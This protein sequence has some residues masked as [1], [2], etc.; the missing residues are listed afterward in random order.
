MVKPLAGLDERKC[1]SWG[2]STHT[3]YDWDDEA[4]AHAP[5]KDRASH[6]QA[7]G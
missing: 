7:L 6:Q 5:T 3:G 2:G 4:V 1:C